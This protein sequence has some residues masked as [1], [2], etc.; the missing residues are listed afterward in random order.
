ME[1]VKLEE[2]DALLQVS[3][4]VCSVLLAAL[5]GAALQVRGGGHVLGDV[6]GRIGGG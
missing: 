4:R 2:L 6:E 3:R 5:A 1:G